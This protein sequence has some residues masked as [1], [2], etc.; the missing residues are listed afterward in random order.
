M[1]RAELKAQAKARLQGNWGWAIALVFVGTL[2][3]TLIG[4]LTVGILQLMVL[5]GL[6]FT[7]LRFIDSGEQGRSLFN[8]IFSGFTSGQPIAVFLNTLLTYIFTALWSLLFVIPGL[9]KALAYAQVPYILADLQHAGG[10]IGATDAITA[11]RELMHGHK[12]DYF[13]LQLSFVGWGLLA[14][15]TA[16]IGFLWLAP[17]VQATNAAYYRQLAGDR[18]QQPDAAFSDF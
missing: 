14:V 15:C 1:T 7:L 18:F 17:Y 3:A 13:I 4:S 6:S 16:G 5:T 2:F 12:W 8:N 10:E 11:S 9:V